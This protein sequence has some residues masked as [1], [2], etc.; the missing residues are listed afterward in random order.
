MPSQPDKPIR[1]RDTTKRQGSQ[2]K[3]PPK[4]TA[5]KKAL[6]FLDAELCLKKISP[7]AGGFK[8]SKRIRPEEFLGVAASLLVRRRAYQTAWKTL[9]SVRR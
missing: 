6:A 1:Q 8:V 3:P 4:E 2:N 7:P 9:P 5:E